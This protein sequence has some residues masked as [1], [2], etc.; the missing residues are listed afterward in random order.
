MSHVAS[1]DY[2]PG[3]CNIGKS[4][5]RKRLW[6]GI[7]GFAICG[8]FTASV[9]LFS[10]PTIYLLGLVIFFYTGFIGV[11]QAYLGFC[12]TLG[13]FGQRHFEEKE[14]VNRKTDRLHDRTR[15]MQVAFYSLVASVLSTG[16][17]YYIVAVS[18]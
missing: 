11:T 9:V 13:A 17:V 10:L 18:T 3:Q 12:V 14:R 6:I 5:Q 4:E 16:I 7:I 2:Q 15:A 1:E 8:V